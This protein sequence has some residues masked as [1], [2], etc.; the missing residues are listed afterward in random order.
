MP[1]AGGTSPRHVSL[2]CAV[3]CL[4]EESDGPSTCSG[5]AGPASR[6]SHANRTGRNGRHCLT[7]KV[8]R[9]TRADHV[10]PC[11]YRTRPLTAV[12][13]TRCWCLHSQA[14]YSH[15]AQCHRRAPAHDRRL[16][17]GS[18]PPRRSRSGHATDRRN[19]QILAPTPRPEGDALRPRCAPR[20]GQ[21]Q[22]ATRAGD[23]PSPEIEAARLPAVTPLCRSALSPRPA[24]PACH[25]HS[26]HAMSRAQHPQAAH[27]AGRTQPLPTRT[28][29]P[30]AP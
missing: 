20:D 28:V 2:S 1:G 4:P 18:D 25:P 26:A 3:P 6:S 7:H 10:I 15:L 22:S 14:G 19:T 16:T 9:E 23:K 21:A 24:T 5:V 11:V 29:T 27:E 13:S 8:S 12:C 30:S 17:R